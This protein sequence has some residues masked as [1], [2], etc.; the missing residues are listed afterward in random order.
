VPIT[1]DDAGE[2]QLGGDG[3]PVDWVVKMVRLDANRTLS[4]ALSAGGLAQDSLES[5]A[6]RLADFYRQQPAEPLSAKQYLAEVERHVRGN[7]RELADH[8][9]AGD[10]ETVR[11]IH[12]AQLVFLK[13]RQDLFA[14]RIAAGRIVDGHGD[15]RPEHIYLTEPPVAI[16]CIEFN[17]EFRRLDILD[18]LCFLETECAQLGHESIGRVI[19]E[20]CGALL[21]DESPDSLVA[22]YK[23]YRAC[24][25]AKVAVLRA[26]QLT[27]DNRDESIA[28]GRRY[29]ALADKFDK[30]LGPPL[31]IV[32]RGLSGSGKTS[33]ASAVAKE[34]ATEHLQTDHIRAE[35]V[36]AKLLP[37]SSGTAKYSPQN[38]ERVYDELFQRA[39]K[40]SELGRSVI[41]DG[42]FLSA[43]RRLQAV[44]LAQSQGALP[45][46]VECRCPA[47]IAEMRIKKRLN[48]GDSLSEARPELH[49]IQLRDEEPDLQSLQTLAI[50]TAEPVAG[51][52]TDII[53]ELATRFRN[54]SG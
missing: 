46:I 42:T 17:A 29:L 52:V 9:F 37:D 36:A 48:R 35:M 3:E 31:L 2:L 43:A 13:L 22:F 7:L 12:G 34:L 44:Q 50:D 6:V 18:E 26:R 41:L 30:R 5:L 54:A 33:V 38:R 25:R 49:A 15:L 16:D 53:A 47:E 10:I 1:R 21:G 24:V 19:R 23:S 20:Q 14:A 39:I 27:N 11:R 51:N 32:V 4:A 40:L 28:L 8:R 45:L